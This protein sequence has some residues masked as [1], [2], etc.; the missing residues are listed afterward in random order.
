MEGN[1]KEQIWNV[2]ENQSAEMKGKSKE[3]QRSAEEN[4]NASSKAMEGNHMKSKE[5]NGYRKK[6]KSNQ[7][8]QAM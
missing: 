5:I 7:K 4:Q 2:N 6:I 8:T 1:S 3:N